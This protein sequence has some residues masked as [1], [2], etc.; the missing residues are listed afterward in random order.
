MIDQ[1]INYTF[2]FSEDIKKLK[3]IIFHFMV[4]AK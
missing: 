4:K 3:E 2:N 1:K